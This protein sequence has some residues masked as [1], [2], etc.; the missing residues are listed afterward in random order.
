[1][2]IG[3]TVFHDAEPHP[4]ENW[5][6]TDILVNSSNV[7]TIAIAEK[8][9][10]EQ[11]DQYL[12]SFGF[13]APTALH[14]PGESAGLLINT[15][16]WSGTSIATVPIGQGLAVTAIQM[17]SAYN[18][19]ANGGIYVSPKLIK[20]TVDSKGHS[21]PTATAARR[22][23]VSPWVAADMT[24]MLGEVVRVGTGTDAKIDGYTVAGKTGTAKV[25]LEG[26]RGYKDGVYAA[27]FAGFVPAERPALT[28]IVILDETPEFGGSVAAPVFAALSRYALREFRI[29]PQP[30][31][32]PAPGVPLA[33]AASALGGQPTHSSSPSRP[34]S[35]RPASPASPATTTTL[36]AGS[37]PT[38]R[39]TSTTST[40]RP[41]RR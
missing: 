36:P 34:A 18:T 5:T 7:G 23:V 3:G 9:G 37:I 4:V 24:T 20:A 30:P 27:S 40:T 6:V 8:L 21:H 35:T 22:P 38:G 28:A 26:S 17:L 31:Q 13:G 41:A 12:R 16:D 33:T 19:I 1:V 14:Y 15:K 2:K 29:P 32:P 39:A 25:P 10:R 11:L